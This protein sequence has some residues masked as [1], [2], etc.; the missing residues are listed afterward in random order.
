MYWSSLQNILGGISAHLRIL[1][2]ASSSLVFCPM[3]YLTLTILISN[4]SIQEASCVPTYFC[5]P[6][7]WY[8]NTL[9]AKEM[10]ELKI[11]EGY[12][13]CNNVLQFCENCSHILS[14]F[15][16]L[17]FVFVSVISSRINFIHLGQKSNAV[18]KPKTVKEK[19]LERD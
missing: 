3:N 14:D 11:S 16:C 17:L 18:K 12:L 6:I 7:P 1:P 19:C 5:L 13:S 9:P 2:A 10:T 4:F 15:C 8:K